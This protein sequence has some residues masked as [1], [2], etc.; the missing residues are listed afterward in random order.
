MSKNIF[1]I[2]G[3][4]LSLAVI[5]AN[6]QNAVVN[7][8]ETATT[9]GSVPVT[10]AKPLP[11]ALASSIPVGAVQVTANNTGTTAATAAALG[12]TSGKTNYI[13]GFTI[14]ASATAGIVGTAT[15]AGVITGTLSFIQGVGTSPAVASLSQNF[16][17]CIAASA[18]NT[19]IT[20][21]SAA[22]STG[23]NTSVTVWGY[24]Q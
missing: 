11:V 8:K 4:L 3:L 24:R 17:P 9:P 16:S 2:A 18:A 6:A 23:G 5:P 10:P 21:T 15:V 12:A 13:C 7:Y 19:A 14:N 1:V 22:A 20:V